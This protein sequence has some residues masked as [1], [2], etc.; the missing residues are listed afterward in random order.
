MYS[1][2]FYGQMLADTPRLHAY[3]AA[4]EKSVKRVSVVLDLGCGPGLFALLAC[5]FG[6]RRVYAV[7]RD[8]VIQIARETATAN[9]Y[10]DRIEFFQKLSTEITV[11]ERADIII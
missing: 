9:G 6:A 4:L 8:D 10:A 3:V 5:K 2:Y 11:P 7:E 1:V